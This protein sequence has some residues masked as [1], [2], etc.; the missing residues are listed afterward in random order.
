MPV[1]GATVVQVRCDA[2]R[3]HISAG[4]RQRAMPREPRSRRRPRPEEPHAQGQRGI[5]GRGATLRWMLV[6]LRT[7]LSTAR[8]VMR[9]GGDGGLCASGTRVP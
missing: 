3:A 6:I 4:G 9:S 5:I 1:S 7:R 8:S 2:T